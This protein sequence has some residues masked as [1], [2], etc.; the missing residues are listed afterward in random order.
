MTNKEQWAPGC[1]CCIQDM[2]WAGMLSDLQR[3]VFFW[4]CSQ[5]TANKALQVDLRFPKQQQV[6][7]GNSKKNSLFR[8]VIPQGKEQ[9]DAH[10]SV[11]KKGLTI[12]LPPLVPTGRGQWQLSCA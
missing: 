5:V 3:A 2:Q 10:I 7:P 11:Q 6:D 12:P 1:K 8:S 4:P 9:S